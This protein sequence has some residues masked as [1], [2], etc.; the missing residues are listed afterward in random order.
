MLVSGEKPGFQALS[1]GLIVLLCAEVVQQGVPDHGTDAC[2]NGQTIR[3]HNASS[4]ICRKD[5]GIKTTHIR[6]NNI[7]TFSF[8]LTVLVI[9]SNSTL[10]CIFL[11][12]T[13]KCNYSR[14]STGLMPF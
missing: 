6:S 4:P 7:I 8:C 10:G 12:I 3:K 14:F 2:T 1:K 9:N 5:G 11:M 13:V